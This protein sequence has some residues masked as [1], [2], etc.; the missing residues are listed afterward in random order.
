MKAKLFHLG[1]QWLMMKTLN[2]QERGMLISKEI[3]FDH[4]RLVNE[5]KSFQ[6]GK[7]VFKVGLTERVSKYMWYW[8]TSYKSQ[9]L[10]L[11]L[12][13]VV[14]YQLKCSKP[15]FRWWELFSSNF[16]SEEFP[17]NGITRA[18]FRQVFFLWNSFYKLWWDSHNPQSRFW[19]FS[20]NM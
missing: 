6:L 20:F 2:F 14:H 1:I 12:G 8:K 7:K 16:Y 19:L 4:W 11:T 17:Q 10:I 3:S 15:D 5:N 13:K 9:I 18:R